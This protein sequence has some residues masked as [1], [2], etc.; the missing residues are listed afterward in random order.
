MK[1]HPNLSI[2][3]PEAT[4]LSRATSFNGTNVGLFFSKLGEVMDRYKFDPND[5]W[6]VDETGITTV[7]KPSKQ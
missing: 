5:I 6:N 3:T 2:R 1:R 4:N 7:Q